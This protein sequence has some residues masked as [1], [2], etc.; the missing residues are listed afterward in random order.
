MKKTI[1]KDKNIVK[2][3]QKGVRVM[4]SFDYNVMLQQ[5]EDLMN[6]PTYSTDCYK[7]PNISYFFSCITVDSHNA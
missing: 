7:S 4:T 5:Y 6:N 2:Q 1:Q 3:S